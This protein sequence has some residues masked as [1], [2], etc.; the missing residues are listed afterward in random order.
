MEQQIEDRKP[1]FENRLQSGILYFFIAVLVFATLGFY[2]TYLRHFPK[3]QGFN[4]AHHFH[5]LMAT[6]WIVM[7]ISQAWLIRLK[8]YAWHRIVGK[9]SYIIMPLLLISFFFIARAAYLKNITLMSEHDALAKMNSGIPDILYMGTLYSLAIIYKKRTAWHLRFFACT[10]FMTLGPGLGRFAFT[11]LPPPV[12]IAILLTSLS[13]P[14]IWLI[15]DIAKRKSPIPMLIYLVIFS[16][17]LLNNGQANW[18]Q[19]F[20]RWVVINLF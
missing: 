5:G 1:A 18:W 2:P 15:V 11:N 20:A 8:K 7:L 19:S 17:A 6:L 13:L 9:C 4:W 14:V 16:S 10:G 12:A 3:F